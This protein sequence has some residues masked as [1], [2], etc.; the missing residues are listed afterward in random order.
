[1]KYTFYTAVLLI[2]VALMLWFTGCGKEESISTF[3]VTQESVRGVTTFG[4]D[5]TIIVGQSVDIN[6]TNYFKWTYAQSI[7][8]TPDSIC[9]GECDDVEVAVTATK[10]DQVAGFSGKICVQNTGEF[11]TE[12]L[13]ITLTV[14]KSCDGGD[15]IVVRDSVPVSV[16]LK[17]IL[18]AGESYCY[19]YA[20]NVSRFGGIDPNCLY[21]IVANVMITN[22]LE[23]LGEPYGVAPESPAIQVCA[24]SN[25]CVTVTEVIGAITPPDPEVLTTGWNITAS[26]LTLEFCETGT[27]IFRLQVCNNGVDLEETFTVENKLL[28]GTQYVDTASYIITTLGCTPQ[29]GGCTRTIGFYKTHAVSHMCGHNPD[30]VSAYL[31]IYLGT[32]MGVKTIAVTRNIQVA[33][34]MK[35]DGP[36]G[37]SNGMLK[38]YAQLLAAKLN[39]AGANGSG[40]PS[41]GSCIAAMIADADAFLATHNAFDWPSLTREQKNMVLNWMNTFDRYNNGLMCAPH[42]ENDRNRNRDRDHN[43]HGHRH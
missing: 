23:H 42:C 20:V 13:A 33:A 16:S 41:D 30:M 28:V 43:R 11:S 22:Y 21:K 36:G 32:P 37:S 3:P 25:S 38:L 2:G 15:F 6:C 9:D 40:L 24:P 27:A 17:P 26:P 18:V 34:I 1:M 8:Q 29:G 12:N 14:M 7:D 39:I 19:V 4:S 5:G 31:P 35:R 10:V